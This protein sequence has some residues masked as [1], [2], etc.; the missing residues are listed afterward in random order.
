MLPAA[1]TILAPVAEKT[2]SQTTNVVQAKK[3]KKIRLIHNAYVYKVNG[4]RTNQRILKKG[5]YIKTISSKTI[6]G[7]KYLKIG[8]NQYV[9]FV[10][11]FKHIK[12]KNIAI[13]QNNEITIQLKYTSKIL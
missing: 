11:T 7:K 9:K 6:K 1:L 10:N 13:N 5:K 8:K 2:I 4:K 3:F 12:K